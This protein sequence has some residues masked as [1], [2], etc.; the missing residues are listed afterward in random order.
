VLLTLVPGAGP[1]DASAYSVTRFDDPAPNGCNVGDCSLREAIIAANA[2][3]SVPD[4]ISLPPGIYTLTR[5]GAN[6]DAAATGDLDIAFN[7]GGVYIYGSSLGQVI[8]CR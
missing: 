3:T 2:S 8:I 5:A 4:T 1:A 6:E 7:S